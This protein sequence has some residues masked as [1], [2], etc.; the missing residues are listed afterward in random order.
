MQISMEK[1]EPKM[2]AKEPVRCILAINDKLIC[3]C[4]QCIY[5]EV[6]ITSSKDIEQEVRAQ[7]NRASRI[8]GYLSG[9]TCTHICSENSSR[10][11]KGE[12]QMRELKTLKTI[13]GVSLRD[14]IRRKVIREDLEIQDINDRKSMGEMGYGWH[15]SKKRVLDLPADLPRDCARAGHL[16]PKRLN[17][18]KKRRPK[19]KP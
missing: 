12:E 14:Q 9:E 7:I 13:K 6:V 10:C 18:I 15:G 17:N 11:N 2:I 3:Q 19:I 1:T 4:M 8:S 5:L 16:L